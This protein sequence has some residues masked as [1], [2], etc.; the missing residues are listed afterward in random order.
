VTTLQTLIV[1]GDAWSHADAARAS[2]LILRAVQGC[3]YKYETD[4]PGVG[5]DYPPNVA[6]AAKVL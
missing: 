6:A 4:I 3:A 2:R 5:A 1:D